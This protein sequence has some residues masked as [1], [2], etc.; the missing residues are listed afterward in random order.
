MRRLAA[1]LAFV[2]SSRALPALASPE[3]LFG[4]GPRSSA[5]AGA[6]AALAE[7]FEAV[8]ANPALLS[9]ER[10]A[11][12]TFGVQGALFDLSA[13]GRRLPYSSLAGSFIGATLPLPF[14]GVLRDRIALGVG[15]FTPFGLV[16]RGRI[17]YP[18]VQQFPMPDRAQSVAVQAGIGVEIGWGLRVG[19]GFAALAALSGAVLVAQDS[20]GRIG[21]EVEDSLV[22]AYAPVA[23]VSFERWGYRAGLTFRGELAARFNVVITVRDLG[24]L[25]VPPLNISGNAQYDPLQL[26]LEVARVAGPLRLSLGATYKRWSAFPGLAEATVRCPD[27]DPVT[28]GPFTDPCEPLVPKPPGYSDTV[29]PR[30]GLEV[31]SPLNRRVELATRAGWAFEPSPAPEQKDERNQYDNDRTIVGAGFGVKANPVQLD[32]FTQLQFLHGRSHG[33]DASVP[34]SNPGAG[35]VETGGLVTAMGATLTGRF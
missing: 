18:E 29:V 32:V 27:K 22:A 31:V 7:G 14:K 1:A 16:V 19:G 10:R 21:T 28:G 20:S 24:S 8:W 23:S 9:L 2:A 11:A 12:V 25:T 6:T 15:F 26:S 5:M 33:K 4:Y 13:S 35:R 34:A 30:V 3:D 17:L